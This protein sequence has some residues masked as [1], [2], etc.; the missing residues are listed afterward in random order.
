ML[1]DGIKT[2]FNAV[3]SIIKAPFNLLIAGANAIIS[4]YADRLDQILR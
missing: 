1:G 4:Y 3:L 2:V